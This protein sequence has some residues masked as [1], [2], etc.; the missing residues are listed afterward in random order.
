MKEKDVIV[1]QC[2]ILG[3]NIKTLRKKRGFSVWRTAWKLGISPKTLRNI[4]KGEI[5]ENVN[6]IVL[7]R[8]ARVFEIDMNRLF[9]PN[10]TLP[11]HP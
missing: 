8:V 2:R 11:K 3:E 4:E 7:V 5:E 10:L 1:D 6:V 9:N